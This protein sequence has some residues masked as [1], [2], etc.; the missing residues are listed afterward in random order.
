M[1]KNKYSYIITFIIIAVLGFI[2]PINWSAGFSKGTVSG[3]VRFTP[4]ENILRPEGFE[5]LFFLSLHH[6]KTF[7]NLQAFSKFMEI[8]R[9][10]STA[11]LKLSFSFFNFIFLKLIFYK[12]AFMGM[13]KMKLI[14]RVVTNFQTQ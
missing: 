11:L 7:L 2:I 5:I 4:I 1:S 8:I 3:F 12:L 13:E 9:L 6:F 10:S 14:S